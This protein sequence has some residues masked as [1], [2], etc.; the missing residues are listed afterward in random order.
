VTTED[1]QSALGQASALIDLERYSEA[2]ERAQRVLS[3]EPGNPNAAAI[4]AQAALGLGDPA[5]ALTMA[6]SAASAAPEWWWP[7]LLMSIALGR[8]GD[9]G[10]AISAAAEAVRLAPDSFLAHLRSAEAL[11][12][13][14]RVAEAQ[15]AAAR[16]IELQ[17]NFVGVHYVS[18]RIA[19][20]EGRESD[21]QAAFKRALAIDPDHAPSHNELARMK[22]GRGFGSAFR[23]GALAE[24]SGGFAA[25]VRANPKD[26][27]VRRNLDLTVLSFLRITA[28][29]VF[30]AALFGNDADQNGHGNVYLPLILLAL[31]LGYAARFLLRLNP[32]LRGYV[33]NLIRHRSAV[34][35]P[36][37]LL[38]VSVVLIVCEVFVDQ[39]DAD[40]LTGG[41]LLLAL[42]SRGLL[43][44]HRNR[45]RRK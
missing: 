10:Q 32:Q 29:F 33:W 18:G 37:A 3:S 9:H 41:A 13:G 43:W 40:A 7:Y 6:R 42:A 31:P 15:A 30:I 36:M 12:A 23:A 38:A 35:T 39:H 25:A 14:G 20:A 28:Y 27:Q 45:V 21:A 2:A 5:R 17:P 22:L 34:R 24:A 1:T 44:R 16:A 8:Q 19:R 4:V 26:A 11:L